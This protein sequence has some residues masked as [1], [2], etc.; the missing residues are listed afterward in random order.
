MTKIREERT[1]PRDGFAR[2]LIASLSLRTERPEMPEL[3]HPRARHRHRHRRCHLGAGVA[4]VLAL[5]VLVVIAGC[6]S[7]APVD[8]FEDRGASTSAQT[9]CAGSG[10]AICE[11]AQACTPYWFAR[12]YT[13]VA[14]CSAVFAEKCLARYRGPGA[15]AEIADCSA[16]IASLSCDELLDPVVVT[17]FDPSVLIAS[18][19]VT[20]GIFGAGDR[21]LRDGDCTTGHC[22]WHGDCGTCSAPVAPLTFRKV[23]EACTSDG[24]CASRWCS[25]GT[26]RELPK[27]GEACAAGRCDF[28]A[29]LTCGSDSICRP[30]GAASLGQRCSWTDSCEAGAT[31]ESKESASTGTCRPAHAASV[32]EDC[33]SGCATE[34]TCV[35]DKCAVPAAHARRCTPEPSPQ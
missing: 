2:R 33:K 30:F 22:G 29:G 6:G 7:V 27:R 12:F 34:L 26:C 25:S 10:A 13:S 1:E 17:Y 32:G 19:P 14:T 11:R 23:G 20:P 24:A 5:L 9:A 4:S 16:T 21:C 35:S 28:L 18:C 15:A 31:C 3:R 8:T